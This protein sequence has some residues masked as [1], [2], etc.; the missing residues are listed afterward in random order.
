MIFNIRGTSGSGKTFL[1]RSI[2]SHYNGTEITDDSGKIF[3]YRLPGNLRVLGRYD[4]AVKGGGV[5]NVTNGLVKRFEAVGGVGNSMDA[6]EA[7][8]RKWANAGRHVIFEGLIVTSV[9]SRWV[10]MAEDLPCF[11]L[12]MNTPL[13][14]C[15][16]RVMERSGGR[17]PKHWPGG[18]DL[19]AKY[20]SN[21]QRL[22]SLQKRAAKARRQLDALRVHGPADTH[23]SG[24]E[25]FFPRTNIRQLPD[26]EYHD[27][28][29]GVLDYENCLEELKNIL[30]T[31]IP[32]LAK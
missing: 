15:F 16:N 31:E 5:D 17:V 3:G 12:F 8:V 28:R 14:V 22:G 27:L 30:E 21:E 26:A 32:D 2:V 29:F 20:R 11:F 4:D 1:V 13:M 19:E 24:I 6:V 7:Q 23:I 9:W 18:S 10:R 25:D